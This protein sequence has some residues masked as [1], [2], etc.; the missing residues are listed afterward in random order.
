M[1]PRVM[2]IPVVEQKFV[3]VVEF[4]PTGLQQQTIL[5]IIDS[6]SLH[7]QKVVQNVMKNLEGN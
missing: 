1:K 2:Y 6:F 7:S 3:V 5:R 4:T